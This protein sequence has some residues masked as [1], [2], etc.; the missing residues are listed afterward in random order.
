[1]KGN[2]QYASAVFRMLSC[3][4]NHRVAYKLKSL[5]QMSSYQQFRKDFAL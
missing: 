5:H 1:M 4:L 3:E 2:V